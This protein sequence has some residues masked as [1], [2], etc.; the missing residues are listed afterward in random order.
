[1]N[2]LITAIYFFVS[3]LA[4]S[5]CGG[6]AA[7]T[8]SPT[9][10]PVPPTASPTA[11]RPTPDISDH[12]QMDLSGGDVQQGFN[13]AIAFNCK[14]CHDSVY[15]QK[16]PRFTATDD[17][18]PILERGEMRI[19]DPA[20]AGRATTNQEYLLES[21]FIPEAHQAPGEWAVTMDMDFVER[22]EKEELIDLLAWLEIF[23]AADD[24]PTAT[25]PVPAAIPSP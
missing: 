20:Y 2:S 18:P 24:L 11:A 12:L 9:S 25:T 17:L 19:A 16:G 8:A 14:V 13:V 23:S 5:A 10:T 22:I 6:A 1:M 21:I 15:P 3:V 7:A 4:L